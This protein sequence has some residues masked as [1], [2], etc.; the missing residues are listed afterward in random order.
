[1]LAALLALLVTADALALGLGG[2]RTQ[3]ALNAPFYG[4]IDLIGVDREELDTVTARLASAEAFEKAGADRPHF[5]TRLRFVT[6]IGTS[7]RPIIQVTSR[8]PIREPYMD[9]LVEVIWPEGTLVKEYAILLDPP[10]T[11]GRPAPAIA[12]PATALPPRAGGSAAPHSGARGD[13]SGFPPR[14]SSGPGGGY[15]GTTASRAA[16]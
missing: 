2:L 7:G 14:P 3:S 1:M 15:P 8:E 10:G 4:E 13:Q 5:L 9:F 6:M 11:T 16:W 12:T